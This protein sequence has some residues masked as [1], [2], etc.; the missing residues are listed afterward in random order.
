MIED[1]VN[2]LVEIMNKARKAK[3]KFDEELDRIIDDDFVKEFE[4]NDV[5][6]ELLYGF[7]DGFATHP[8]TKKF[9]TGMYVGYGE[10]DV[11]SLTIFKE[12]Q[13]EW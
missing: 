9:L 11:D 1:K 12:G 3:K 10:E 13:L 6:M 7:I 8:E 5:S 4:L 2:R